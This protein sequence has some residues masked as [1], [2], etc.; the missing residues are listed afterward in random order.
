MTTSPLVN[1][2]LGDLLE[3]LDNAFEWDNYG[4]KISEFNLKTYVLDLIA[5]RDKLRDELADMTC[6]AEIWE[7]NY[8]K[9]RDE[10]WNKES[11]K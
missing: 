3:Y 2:A 1:D 11:P 10:K 8:Y 5:Q 9:L 6:H 4:D 7:R